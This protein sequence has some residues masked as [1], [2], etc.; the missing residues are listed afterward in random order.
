MITTYEDLRNGVAVPT[1][2]YKGRRFY[3]FVVKVTDGE[4]ASI[5]QENHYPVIARVSVHARSAREAVAHVRKDYV[6]KPCLTFETLG[7]RA[8]RYS[9]F[10]GWETAIAQTLA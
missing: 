1:G 10:Q 2:R 5:L 6:G 3:R 4:M 8:G 7:P 9:E